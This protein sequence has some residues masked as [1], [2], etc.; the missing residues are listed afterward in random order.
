[1]KA[2]IKTDTQHIMPMKKVVLGKQVNAS[3]EEP[4]ADV[5]PH[6]SCPICAGNVV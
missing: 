2:D 4:A 6:H 5:N 1:M 3:P